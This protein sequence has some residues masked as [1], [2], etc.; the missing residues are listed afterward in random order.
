MTH[1]IYVYILQSEAEPNRFYTGSTR[2]LRE[3]ITRHNA[4]KVSHT[5]KWKPGG[6]NPTLRPMT[7]LAR[8]N[9]SS[10]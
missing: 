7:K 4:G 6:W 8:E 10:I 1:F 3:R 2:D 5:A 9:S